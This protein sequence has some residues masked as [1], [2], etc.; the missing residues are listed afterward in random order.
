VKH[1][2]P[3][4]WPTTRKPGL[5]FPAAVQGRKAL[6]VV[7]ESTEVVDEGGLLVDEGTVVAVE[8]PV[9][10]GEIDGCVLAD[11]PWAAWELPSQPA[12]RA[13]SAKEPKPNATRLGTTA[14][15]RIDGGREELKVGGRA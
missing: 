13:A 1:E 5:S 2:P 10:A 12:M 15:S 9:V 8:G 4:R 7:D 14:L 3:V 11:G 6:T